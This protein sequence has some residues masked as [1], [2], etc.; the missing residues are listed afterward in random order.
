M[1]NNRSSKKPV[2]TGKYRIKSS[3]NKYIVFL[4][5]TAFVSSFIAY[6]L[7]V[8]TK[9]SINADAQGAGSLPAV[10]GK[11]I[12]TNGCLN[13]ATLCEVDAIKYPGA[14]MRCDASEKFKQMSNAFTIKFGKPLLSS[15][16]RSIGTNASGG[17]FYR[18]LQE[19]KNCAQ[20]NS[21]CGTPGRSMHGWGLA[22]D[23]GAGVNSF[24]TPE[25]RW[26][27][28]N[29]CRWGFVNPFITPTSGYKLLSPKGYSGKLEPWH[30]EFRPDVCLGNITV[31]P[32]P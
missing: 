7:T 23:I 4:L 11:N 15:S 2:S 9:K 3:R 5:F 31:I 30:W 27:F 25:N 22:V 21:N 28:D 14:I 16:Q 12:G 17:D 8:Y 29:S 20:T 1:P 10:C 24:G 32:L 18:N 13:T 6:N 19:Q 26:I